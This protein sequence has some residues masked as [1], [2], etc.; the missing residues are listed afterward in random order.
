MIKMTWKEEDEYENVEDTGSGFGA[1]QAEASEDGLP[2]GVMLRLGAYAERTNK[3]IEDAK[4]MYL[5]YITTHYGCD[6]PADEDEDLLVDWAEQVFTE[7]RK[8]SGGSSKNLSTWVGS[9]L[10]VQDRK[11]DRLANIVQSNLKLYADDPS[12]AIGSGRLGAYEKTGTVWS[13]HTKD[14][15]KKLEA[16]SDENPPYGLQ[17]GSDWVCLTSYNGDPAPYKRMGRYAYFLG[18][19]EEQLVKN[20]KVSLWRVDLTNELTELN[21]QQG[22]PCKIQVV[23]PKDNAREAFKDVLGVYSNFEIEYTDEFL[24]E[25]VRPLLQPSKFWTLPAFHEYYVPI[26]ELDDAYERGKQSG[27]IGG[28]RR[29][30]GPLVITRGLVTS[31]NSEPRESDF[32][33]EGYNYS[34]TL[35]SSITGDVQCWIAGAVGNLTQPF[36]AGWGEEAFE[37]AERSTVL[38][39]GRLGMKE[40]NGIVSPKISVMGVFAD[41]RRSRQRA[42]GG[43]TGVGQFD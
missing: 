27:D 19:E 3:T 43:D 29:Q 12:E 25:D 34:M 9:F 22:R 31:L 39:F 14:G 21:I 17:S 1:V 8:Q 32:D 20:N 36:V 37:Y 35:S 6:S 4:K 41:P 13:L 18:H 11:R 26:D 40:Y 15:V 28:E 38:V 24:P 33:P 30:W 23:P 7:T 16:S 10:G 42:T 5:E 2:K